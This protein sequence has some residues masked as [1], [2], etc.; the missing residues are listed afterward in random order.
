MAFPPTGPTS[1][2]G[3]L[4]AYVYQQF[5]DDDNIQAFNSAFNGMAQSY[6]DWFNSIN[7]PIYTG[8]QIAGPLL[9]WV[10]QGIYG[11]S[12]PSLPSGQ[13]TGIGL[14]G[15]WMP[16]QIEVAAF[17]VSGTATDYVV[18]DDIFKRI[19][20]WFFFKGDGQRFCLTW[21]KRRIM[22]FLVGVNGTAPNI[23]N[24]YPVS[25]IYESDDSVTITITITTSNGISLTAAQI[26]Q[27]A[28]QGGV[29]ALPFQWP[30]NVLVVNNAGSTGLNNNS[31]VLDVTDA[32]GWPTSSSG[33]S[34]GAVWNNTGVVNVVSGSSPD[35]TAPAVIYGVITAGQLLSLGGEN[36]PTS[37]P[38]VLNQ[39]WNNAGVANVSA[40]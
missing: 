17:V 23:D 11:I 30:F 29:L 28:V 20:T 26:F 2:A 24:T 10:A 18:T 31:G 8:A 5:S 7:L 27:A 33:L 38:H 22:R 15:T 25:T 13:V 32:T 6:Q 12:R 16:A 9:D 34:A 21:L 35:P 1:L 14:V 4:P 40:G 36:L 19:I 37:D 3:I 39:I